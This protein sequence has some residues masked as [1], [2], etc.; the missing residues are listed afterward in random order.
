MARRTNITHHD[1]PT[2]LKQGTVSGGGS[3]VSQIQDEA[4]VLSLGA[5]AMFNFLPAASVTAPADGMY[6]I[7]D[8]TNT[9][10]KWLRAGV[11]NTLSTHMVSMPQ[12]ADGTEELVNFTVPGAV[13]G[14]SYAFAIVSGAAPGLTYALQPCSATDFLNVL[15]TNNSGAT[16]TA[17]NPVINI[18]RLK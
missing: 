5:D 11:S 16:V 9:S 14:E 3:V 15:V 18:Y 17:S 13:P 12:L 6:V 10:G 2:T 4:I 8:T 1:T 7:D